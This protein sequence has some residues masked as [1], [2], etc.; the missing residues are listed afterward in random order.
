MPSNTMI[1]KVVALLMAV[2]LGLLAWY[3]APSVGQDAPRAAS[4]TRPRADP[5]GSGAPPP[6]A[7]HQAETASTYPSRRLAEAAQAQAKNIL[8]RMDGSFRA[9]VSPPF[10]VVGNLPENHLRRMAEDSVMAPARAMWRG[11]FQ[12]RPT[13]VITVLLFRDGESYKL[14]AKKLLNDTRVPYFG[15]YKPAER[16]MVMNIST[17]TGTLVHELT[18]ALIV[19]DFPGVP[20]WFNEGLASLHE[21]CY[22]MP[23]RLVGDVNWRLPHLQTAIRQNKLRPLRE[24]VTRDDFYG[25]QQ[26]INYAQ[27]RYFVMYLQQQGLLKEFYGRFRRDGAEKGAV[28]IIEEVLAAPIEQVEADYVKWAATLRWPKR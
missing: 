20:T 12:R 9:V 14:W 27:A 7:T 11:Y 1:V 18:H 21:Q 22:V 8:A 6:A 13:H 5:A 28:K 10:V 4:D 24:L 15:Y 23:D 17:G 19:Y 2:G 25:P 16:I 26:G 3:L